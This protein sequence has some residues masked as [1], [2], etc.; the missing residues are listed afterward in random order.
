M[1]VCK[2][3]FSSWCCGDLSDSA[4][5]EHQEGVG[6]HIEAQA[7]AH[8]QHLKWHCLEQNL[9][10]CRVQTTIPLAQCR[11]FSQQCGLFFP[12][13]FSALLSREWSWLGSGDLSV[14]APPA[15]SSLLSQS[16]THGR[17][18]S[19]WKSVNHQGTSLASC[20]CLRVFL[21]TS[22]VGLL[23]QPGWEKKADKM[24]PTSNPLIVLIKFIKDHLM[25]H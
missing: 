4:E 1:N 3:L 19:R 22:C 16:R 25:I 14:N 17:G 5:C 23:W 21:Q 2:T 8:Q 7:E 18:R 6:G 20:F 15:T 13:D 10:I 11:R 12:A 9:K 24:V